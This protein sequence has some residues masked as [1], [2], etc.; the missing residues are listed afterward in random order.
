MQER[1]LQTGTPLG[2]IVFAL[3]FALARQAG[4]ILVGALAEASAHSRSQTHGGFS[5]LVAQTVGRG[6]R[7]FPALL[8][9]AV[10]KIN[11]RSLR[12]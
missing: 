8:A 3:A 2:S 1:P 12:W 7:I 9:I 6:E 5:K 4:R 10:E 11:L